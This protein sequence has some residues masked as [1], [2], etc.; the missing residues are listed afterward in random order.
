[1][2]PARV[3]FVIRVV[4]LS[5]LLAISCFPALGQGTKIRSESKIAERDRDQPRRRE[6]W[7]M[8][9]RVVPGESGAALRYRAHAQKMELRAE[10]ALRMNT[11]STAATTTAIG[12]WTPLGPA[13][14]A[15][16]ATGFSQQD[17]G[18][19]SGRA[20]AVA[21]DPADATGDTVYVGGA[22]GGVWKSTNA[23][24]LSLSPSNVSWS[25]LIDNQA[26]L[27]VGSI[28]VQPGNTDPTKSVILVGTGET[29]SSM[30]SYYGLGILRSADAGNTWT[31][32][33]QDTGGT[34]PFAGM[35]FSKIAFSMAN[36]SLV[37]AAAAGASQGVIDGL[38]SPVNTN[39]G[40]YYSTNGGVSWSYANI[41]DVGTPIQPNS[42]TSVIYNAGAGKFFAA[43]RF[44]GF[45]S[46]SDGVNWTRLATQPGGLS[47]F[48]CP[49]TLASQGCPIYRGEFAAV[50]GRNEMYAWYVDENENDQGIWQTL[51]GGNTWTQLDD[52]SI[53]NCGDFSGGCGTAQGSYNLE[54]A[55]V[56]NGLTATDLY[57]GAINLYKCTISSISPFC[58]G[59]GSGTFLNLTH[60][61]G[62]A[63][64]F[65]SIAH[66]H[67]DQHDLDFMVANSKAILYFANDGG[68]YRALDG[69]SGLTTSD[70]SGSNQFD[71]L[72]QTL[73]SM[74]QFVSFSQHPSDPNTIL[75]GTQDNGSPATTSAEVSASW[76]NV[77]SGDGGYTA[78]NPDN[79]T[80]WFT[81]NTN[82]SIQKCELAG[83]CHAQDFSNGLV[84]S[85]ATVGG[86]SGA[87]YTP[88][89]LDPQ[90]SATLIVGTCRM[91]RG[92]TSGAGF[93]V[94][95]N[96]FETG[97]DGICSGNEVNLV[98]SL[99]AG[100]IKDTSGFSNVMYAGT[101]GLGPLMPTGGHVWVST[102]VDS[103]A[104]FDRTSAINPGK[105]PVSSAALDPSDKTGKT[106]YV[107]IMGFHVAH[108][109][110]TSNGGVNWTNFTANLPDAPVNA[111]LIDAGANPTTGTIYV[112]TDVGV[113]SSSTGT[114]GWTEVGPAPASSQAGFLP[115]VSVTA[116]RMFNSGGNKILR[117]STYGRGVWQLALTAAPDFEFSIPNNTATVFAGQTAVFNGTVL[118][119]NGYSSAVNLG[120]ST[121]ATPPPSTCALTPANVTPTTSFSLNASGPVGDYFFNAHGVGTDPNT[122]IRNFALT[123]HVVD[124]AMTALAPSSVT[125]APG[126]SSGPVGFQVTAAGAFNAA[127]ALSCSGLPAGATCSFQPATSVNPVSGVPVPV[128]LTINTSAS[129]PVGTFTVSITGSTT[130]GPSRSENLSLIVK[131]VTAAD[132]IINVSNSPQTAGVTGTATFNGTLTSVNG[133]SSSVTL[134]CGNGG[135]VTCTPSS[136][137]VT[138]SA[139]GAA[140]TVSVSSDVV[141]NYNF[142]IIATG[143]DSAHTTHSVAVA[144]NSTFDF[145]INNNSAPETITAGQTASYN[146]DLRPLGNGSTFPAD[147]TLACSGLPALST[148][149]FTPGSVGSGNGDTNV[150]VNVKTTAAIPASAQ[151]TGGS[152]KY[153]LAVSLVSLG[154]MGIRRAPRGRLFGV[155]FSLLMMAGLEIGCGGGNG[156]SG[157]GGAGQPGT[158]AGNYTVTVTA[159]SGSLSHIVQVSLTVH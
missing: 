100:G 157:G 125:V 69:Y 104:W 150:V 122:L 16:D 4:A 15:S 27:A 48:A 149:S 76:F 123:V 31:L 141:Q 96:N 1:M 152:L 47:T 6:Q 53:T 20:T 37:V 61:Y 81:A 105:F 46:S 130:G 103:E 138:P 82:V 32:I 110:K 115:N 86:D 26:T 109:W 78:I 147:V 19:V 117:A 143:S 108:F 51:D 102:N 57:A 59:T 56:P 79:P 90:N 58:G 95:S 24:P 63:P 128:T 91:W 11:A 43:I 144:F 88:Y 153:A 9:G 77:N 134:S 156:G 28:A 154:F 39:R 3:A 136:A 50:P 84:V 55:A 99:A 23:G 5:L 54:L 93:T 36:P 85:N 132:Y 127:V 131:S 159:T 119:I 75:G 74:S 12:V 113:F 151:A 62:C 80:E 158:P 22:Y 44:H 42:A 133:Y 121:G 140:F 70:C 17:Y 72:N 92:S 142:N 120:C 124:F 137:S 83:N 106:A 25:P 66:V 126:N 71:N 116:L 64:N 18:W 129:T 60:V 101:D 21:I 8:H 67:P 135:P 13:P 7:F 112:G 38:E 155:L 87:F 94:L 146:L 30:D 107:A 145:A 52:S 45:Y 139:G 73:G 97:G 14:L 10:R 111:I 35:G 118:A 65:G 98:R 114:A 2:S 40:L 41:S 33:T 49:T 29:N 89:I 148:C 68:I 34:H